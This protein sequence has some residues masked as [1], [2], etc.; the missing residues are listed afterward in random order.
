MLEIHFLVACISE[1][2]IKLKE[3]LLVSLRI[4]DTSLVEQDGTNCT[5]HPIYKGA[6]MLLMVTSNSSNLRGGKAVLI[7]MSLKRQL[8]GLKELKGLKDQKRENHRPWKPK[9]FK[10]RKM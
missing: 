10:G 4:S 9:G 2:G 8:K 5:R 6:Y 1:L 3:C 7:Y